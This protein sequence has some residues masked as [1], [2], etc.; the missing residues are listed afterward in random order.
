MK[1]LE[2]GISGSSI[3]TGGAAQQGVAGLFTWFGTF[4]HAPSLRYWT[5]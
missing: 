5:V 3:N 4:T 1:V 2:L